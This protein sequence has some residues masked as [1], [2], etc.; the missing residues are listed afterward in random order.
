MRIIY[1]SPH[2][3]DAVLSCG[4][5]IWEQTHS[6]TPVEIWTLNAG[7]PAPGPVSDL[8]TRVHSMWQ[9]GSP[10]ETVAQRRSE[11]QNAASQVGATVRHLKMVDAIYR[12]NKTGSLLYTQDVFTP[13]HPSETGIVDEAANQIAME[14]NVSDTVVCPLALGG[15]VDHIIAR[16][17]GESLRSPTVSIW[18]YADI[19][20]LFKHADAL[21][22]VTEGLRAKNFFVSGQGLAAWQAGVT[23][24]ESQISSL[25]VDVEDMRS[26]IRAYCMSGNGLTLWE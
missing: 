17:A 9:T 21:G 7:E 8:I 22:P 24:Y 6:G 2:F 18:Y 23:A 13:I 10:Q 16:L 14:L 1:L 20:Y 12:R 25:F 11:D 19:P 15:H 5:L 3:D 4:G 26:Q